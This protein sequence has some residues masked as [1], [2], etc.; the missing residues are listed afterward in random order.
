MSSARLLRSLVVVALPLVLG[1]TGARALALRAPDFRGARPAVRLTA[2]ISTTLRHTPGVSG[3]AVAAAARHPAP[4]AVLSASVA[5]ALAASLTWPDAVARASLVPPG[6]LAR[7]SA[8]QQSLPPPVHDE[9]TCAFCQAAI[10]PPCAPQPVA[11]S[12]ELLGLVRHEAPP[13]EAAVPQF[14]TH[15]RTS[16]RAPPPL[17]SI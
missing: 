11:I 8:P 12:L 14:S 7:L 16:S 9:A 1:A 6:T 17:Q 10:F 5:R 2:Q 4:P 3:H 15:R 13:T